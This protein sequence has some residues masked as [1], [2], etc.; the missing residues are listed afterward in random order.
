M[1]RRRR[2]DTRE[3]AVHRSIRGREAAAEAGLSRIFGGIHFMSANQQGLQS[4]AR[5]GAYVIE[6]F[7]GE[8]HG[9]PPRPGTH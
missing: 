3:P 4:G 1:R 2:S 5:I 9:R 7:L 6:N 8:V